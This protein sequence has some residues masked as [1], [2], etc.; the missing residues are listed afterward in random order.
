MA[1][2]APAA[3]YGTSLRSTLVVG[4]A[5][6]GDEDAVD[7]HAGN[8]AVFNFDVGKIHVPEFCSTEIDVGEDR[9]AYQEM[10]QLSNQTYVPT[11]VAGDKVLANFDTEQ[12]E[13]FLREHEIHP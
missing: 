3:R 1:T 9:E 12:L 6:L 7:L 4:R 5:Q 11:F 2:P 8:I 10:K 13:E